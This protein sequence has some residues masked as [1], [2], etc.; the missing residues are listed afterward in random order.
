MA[1]I[2]AKG[3]SVSL[4]PHFYS[5]DFDCRCK[6]PQCCVTLVDENL[7]LALEKLWDIVGPFKIDSGNRC[8]EHNEEVGG[9]P[10][11]QHVEGKAADCRSSNGKTGPE[12]AAAAEHVPAF[13]AGGIGTYEVF[14]HCDVRQGKARWQNI[15]C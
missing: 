3:F 6:R 15:P 12:M 11:S 1:Q 2:F 7:P 10:R 4:S 14:A 5:T 13:A 9:A 8:P